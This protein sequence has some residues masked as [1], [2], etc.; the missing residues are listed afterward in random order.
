MI[1]DVQI[2]DA[3]KSQAPSFPGRSYLTMNKPLQ[4]LKYLSC[5]FLA[6]MLTWVL[7]F[8]YRKIY[9]EHDPDWVNNLVYNR[10]FYFGSIGI[11]V[12]WCFIYYLQGNYD[13]PFRRSRLNELANTFFTCLVGVLLLFFVLI[14]DDEIHNYRNYYR[15]FTVLFSL[16]F[17]LTALPRL[18]LSTITNTRIHHRLMGFN[19][20]LIGSNENAWKTFNEIESHKKG[21]GNLFKGFI[22]IDERNGFSE[23]LVKRLPHLGE[24]SDLVPMIRKHDIEEIIIA[25]E[26]SEHNAIQHILND[27]VDLEVKV[28]LIPD[29]YDI[30]SGSVRFTSVIHAPLIEI[31]REVVPRWQINAKRIFDVCFSFFVILGFSWFYLLLSLLV[32]LSSRGPVIFSQERL[33]LHGKP[34]KI[35]KF[36]SMFVDAEKN[37]P[38]LSSDNDPRIT[39]FG[40][41]LRK[42][43][44]DEFPQFFNVLLGHM[45]IV[46][47]R[48]ERK[49]FVDQIVQKAPHYRHLHRVR[50]GIT[51]WGQV[52]FG[53]AEN[54]D[55]MIERLKYDLL[56]TENMSLMVDVKIIIYTMLIVIQGRGK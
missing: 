27:T 6:A 50:P 26:S 1:A 52:K 17:V 14:L 44:L 24:L 12:F 4:A 28:K 41:F 31:N 7:F 9:I 34:F 15:S 29:V 33:G 35:Y 48:P 20:L 32:K 47:P 42:T 11:P 21:N 40:R 18:I 37:G 30:L 45:S 25:L 8:S 5:D 16:Q 22:H 46:G 51:S 55:E 10:K 43:R 19:T 2:T 13:L 54:V 49:F 56:Y 53:Y 36:R 38:A 23:H 39:P 3:T